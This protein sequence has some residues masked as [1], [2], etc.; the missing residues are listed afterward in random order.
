MLLTSCMLV[1]FAES[2]FARTTLKH[3]VIAA[4]LIARSMSTIATAVAKT[5]AVA[6]RE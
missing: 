4:K 5:I 3:A 1:P 6:R 2:L